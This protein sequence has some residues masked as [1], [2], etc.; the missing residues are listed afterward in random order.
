[1]SCESSISISPTYSGTRRIWWMDHHQILLWFHLLA[2]LSTVF[3]QLLV[4]QLTP[5]HLVIV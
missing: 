2:N 3:R 4:L 5:G 1:M